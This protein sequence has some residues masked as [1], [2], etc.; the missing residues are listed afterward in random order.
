M[1]LARAMD[2]TLLG[3]IAPRDAGAVFVN[4]LVASDPRIP[5]GGIE[6]SGYG[7][8]RSALGL[9][10]FMNTKTVWIGAAEPAAS[11]RKAL[12]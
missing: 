12:D 6:K 3:P 11:P 2:A 1:D 4:A 10:A 8:D 5:F 9:R 7:R